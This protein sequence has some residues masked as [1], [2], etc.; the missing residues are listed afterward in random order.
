MAVASSSLLY[1]ASLIRVR[2]EDRLDYRYDY[3]AE[4]AGRM[5]VRT[6]GAYFDTA[7]NAS[8]SLQ[9]NFVYDS[10]SGAT[11][12][13]APPL[14][15]ETS[16]PMA[17]MNDKRYAGFL[18]PTFKF[19]NHAL[20]PQIS[21]SEES[22]Y[23]SFGIALN[24]AMDFNEKNTTVTWGASH[25]FDQVLPNE[26]EKYR[27][28]GDPSADITSPLDKGDTAGF[29]GLSQ[30]L[31]PATVVTANL[32]LGYADGFLN[33]PYKRVLFDNTPYTPGMPYT[34]WPESR[35]GHR[36]RQV[37]FFSL[38]HDFEKAKGAVEL[39]Y[40]FYNDSFGIIGNTASIQWNQK[41]GKRVIVS[42]LFRFHTQ[43]AADFYGTHFPGDPSDPNYPVPLPGSFSSDY[44]LSALETFTYGVTVSAR[45]HKH[46]SLELAYKRFEM[47]GT[48]GVTAAAQYP[49]ANVFAGGLTLWF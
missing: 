4:E 1:L 7:L 45:V 35:P 34:V 32:T 14:P 48:D 27:K 19:S 44:R 37:A 47:F 30:L 9:G 40:R 13:G 17:S 2:G 8:F 24:D 33:D 42:P 22:D 43:T 38:Q 21:Y 25:S 46:L 23:R 10:V 26:G 29:L 49:K 15:G 36:F 28:P 18:Q 5:K 39:T 11:P 16:V 3:Y 31:D 12:T 41:I 6:S 20:S